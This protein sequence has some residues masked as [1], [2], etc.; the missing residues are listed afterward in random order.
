MWGLGGKHTHPVDTRSLNTDERLSWAEGGLFEG[1]DGE[2]VKRASLFE[3]ERLHF[4]M[5]V[6]QVGVMS[7]TGSKIRRIN[8]QEVIGRDKLVDKDTSRRIRQPNQARP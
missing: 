8:R 6:I 2:V 7:T 3:S 1:G 4:Q 5:T